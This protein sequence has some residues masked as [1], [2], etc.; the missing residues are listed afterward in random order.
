[1]PI[2][3]FICEECKKQFDIMISNADKHKVK[4]PDCGS[5]NI[6]QLLSPFS[7]SSKGKA[8]SLHGDACRS[9]KF[10]ESSG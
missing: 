10:G 6:K 5:G 1:M 2:F 8:P 3:D 7:S 4:C 9:C